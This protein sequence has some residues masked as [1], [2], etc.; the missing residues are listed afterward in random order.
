MLE[1]KL[2]LILISANGAP[3][4]L[5]CYHG[6]R[7]SWP[8]DHHYVLADG[9]RLLGPSKTWRGF[10]SGALCAAVVSFLVG[11]SFWFGLLFGF[12]SLV[13][14]ALSSFIKRRMNRP[15]SSRAVGI[16]QIPEAVVPLIFG[17]FYLGYSV[18]TVLIVTLSFFLLNILVSPVLYQMGIRKRPH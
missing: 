17:F 8:V 2:L 18:E 1:L 5:Y 11:L 6:D 3:V 10:L 13:G 12:L 9:K 15:S 4:I 16:D 14:D 7:Y